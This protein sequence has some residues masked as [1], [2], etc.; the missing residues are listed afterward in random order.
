[1]DT[2]RLS[3]RRT[4]PSTLFVHY[5]IPTNAPIEAP[6]SCWARAETVFNARRPQWTDGWVGGVYATLISVVTYFSIGNQI[7]CVLYAVVLPQVFELTLNTTFYFIQLVST[8]NICFQF[9][10]KILKILKITFSLTP[11]WYLKLKMVSY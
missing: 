9:L 11:N 3:M 7:I 1:M 10:I 4:L 5:A 2:L 6:K 8:K